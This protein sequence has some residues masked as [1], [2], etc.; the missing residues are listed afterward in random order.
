VAGRLHWVH[1]ASTPLL[2]WFTVHPK[3]GVVAMD[4]AGVLPGF[5]GVAVHDGWSPYWRYQGASHALCAAH[6]LRELEA[7][8]ELPGQGWAAELGEW[9]TI[10]SA[11]A[12]S[13]RDTGAD[14]LAATI[15]AGLQDRYDRILAKGRAANPPPP[16]PPG[17]RRRPRRSPAVCL[18]D[19]L[20]VHRDEVCRFLEDLRVPPTNN[21]AERDIR[22]VKLQQKISGCW[23]T[24]DGAQAFLTVRSYVATARKHGINPLIALRRLFE[25][26]PWMP[27]PA[28]L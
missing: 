11:Q 5:G 16:R 1:S 2:S 10:A 26:D 4:A 15:L 23:R 14:R 8:A 19:R 18:L 12:A 21:L 28:P 3:R 22:M 25:G 27:A 13:A 17:R 24:L 6:L 9:F 20:E 7:A